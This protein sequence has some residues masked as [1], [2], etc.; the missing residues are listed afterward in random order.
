[1]AH[2]GVQ[3]EGIQILSFLV[4]LVAIVAFDLALVRVLLCVE[5]PD[6][7]RGLEDVEVVG[8]PSNPISTFL[9]KQSWTFKRFN[10]QWFPLLN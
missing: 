4:S 10:A 3:V 1:M 5:L 2:L 9:S 7:K 6:V 8:E